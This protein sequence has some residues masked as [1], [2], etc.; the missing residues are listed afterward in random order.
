MP[1]SLAKKK[2][3]QKT[4]SEIERSIRMAENS[5]DGGEEE[6]D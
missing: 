6:Q 1:K 2:K 3:H 4:E 5:Q